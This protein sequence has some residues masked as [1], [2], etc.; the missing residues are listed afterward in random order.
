VAKSTAPTFSFRGGVRVRD[1]ILAC[2]ASAGS[3]L[4]FL[5]HASALDARAARLLPSPRAGHRQILASEATLTLLGPAGARLRPHTLCPAFGRPF[6]LGGLRLELFPSGHLPGA[7]SLLCEVADQ[8]IVYAGPIA[9]G[10]DIRTADALCVDGTFAQPQFQFPPYADALA[11]VRDH[12][13]AAGA[14][15]KAAVVLARPLGPALDVAQTLV[16]AGITVR[17]HRQ[18][19]AA[20]AAFADAGAPVPPLLRFGGPLAP[21]EALLWPPEDHHAGRLKALPAVVTILASGWAADP[22]TARRLP[23]DV[24]VPL[25]NVGGFVDVL[26]Y[27]AS[28]GA[29]EVAVRHAADDQLVAALAGRQV[30]A[31]RIGPPQQIA[32]F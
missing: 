27:I 17:A 6:V 28:T 13:R 32:L 12:V 5:S 3:D 4:I 1:S 29:R 26:D 20:R 21:G 9:A 16:A 10:A 2:D 11:K 19:I 15:G 25:S 14:D 23:A 8:R 7:S 22:I 31:Y 18:V 24:A 30:A